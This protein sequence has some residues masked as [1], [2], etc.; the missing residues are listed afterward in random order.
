MA[1]INEEDYLQQRLEDQVNWYDKKSS[2]NQHW[3]KSL[4]LVQILC[5]TFIMFLSGMSGQLPYSHWLLSLCSMLMAIATAVLSLNKYHDK[6][7][8][9]RTT[10]ETLKHEKYLYL[11]NVE[12]YH[13]ADKFPL[14]VT[15]VEF[16][17]SSQ[18]S[19]WT[20]VQ[21]SKAKERPGENPV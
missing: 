12:P 13:Q 4:Q 10:S 18:N 14:L 6:W 11:A 7:I 16:I 1:E 17:I 5:S 8:E 2:Q 15:R 19:N 20:K 21:H 3:Y 9:Y